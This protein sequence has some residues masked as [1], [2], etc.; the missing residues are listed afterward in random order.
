[1]VKAVNPARGTQPVFAP[2]VER[3]DGDAPAVQATGTDR[4]DSSPVS[5]TIGK[6]DTIGAIAAKYGVS[7]DQLKQLNPEIFQNGRDGKGQQRA[8]DGHWVYQGDIVRL[9][10]A[11]TPT[12]SPA[13]PAQA[14]D[15]VVGAAKAFIDAAGNTTDP[16]AAAQAQDMLNLIPA[17]DPD[18][19]AYEAKVKTLAA[20]VPVRAPASDGTADMATASE[21]FN[22]ASD[23]YDKAPDD[24]GRAA[25][26]TQSVIAYQRAAEAVRSLPAGEQRDV[27][28]SQLEMMEMRLKS[29]G[30]SDASLATARQ[31]AG[32][33]PTA[34]APTDGA[35]PGA[36]PGATPGAAPAVAPTAAP[37]AAPVD[38]AAQEAFIAA[39]AKFDEA[40]ESY[41]KTLGGA[42]SLADAAAAIQGSQQK[43]LAAYNE[44]LAAG[45]RVGPGAQP[46]LD[47]M[48]Q[49][50]TQ[51]GVAKK[52]IDD[53]KAKAPPMQEGKGGSAQPPNGTVLPVGPLPQGQQPVSPQAQA[54][55]ATPQAITDQFGMQRQLFQKAI[56]DYVNLSTNGD[57]AGAEQARARAKAAYTEAAKLVGQMDTNTKPSYNKLLDDFEDK[58]QYYHVA[59]IAEM[60]PIR[61]AAKLTPSASTAWAPDNQKAGS[62]VP[63]VSKIK[64]AGDGAKPA[65]AQ[66]QSDEPKN[67]D[68]RKLRTQLS[69]M[70]PKMNA[71]QIT[72]LPFD[73]VKGASNDQ[74]G[75][76]LKELLDHWWVGGDKKKY[77]ADVI[78]IAAGEGKI[79]Q[80]LR[81][82]D[83]QMKG[84]GIKKLFSK[85]KGAD[86]IRTAK[87]I[88]WDLKDIN[89]P[90]ADVLVAVAGEMDKDSIRAVLTAY[91]FSPQSDWFKRVPPEVKSQWAKSLGGG[92]FGKS[93]QDGAMI[94]AL[95]AGA[96]QK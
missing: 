21:G 45:S 43:A 75:F 35:A 54:P 62:A 44:A 39:Q 15:R 2:R 29:M 36:T 37:A 25:A 73:S 38:P 77:A 69:Q 26:R 32:L 94:Q 53:A 56:E 20:R 13:Q 6:G 34:A 31:A 89:R 93:S 14:S 30:A 88:F 61:K 91:G 64:A 87:N 7:V 59:A 63:D 67:E 27:A 40:S 70:L 22:N 51:M 71:G 90:S 82:F 66:A 47:A 60:D 86:E 49:R 11:A 46:A 28:A 18:R 17:A 78:E 95:Q 57:Q 85:L 74:R 76:M 42:K 12:P 23:A 55:L 58:L 1:M 84:G 92:W 41:D 83:G 48:A 52:A 5:V 96:A 65:D 80:T 72:K 8:A 16:G 68:E 50:L 79:D 4:L 19:A 9:R 33:P 10:A 3:R 81:E 24:T